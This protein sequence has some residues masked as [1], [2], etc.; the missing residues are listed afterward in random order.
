MLKRPLT[1]ALFCLLASPVL[2]EPYRD[3]AT[4]LGVEI[5]Q[6][7]AHEAGAL[8]SDYKAGV[9]F[10][11][12]GGGGLMCY[13]GFI[14]A[15][16]RSIYPQDY[17]NSAMASAE[18]QQFLAGEIGAV[19]RIESQTIISVNGVTGTEFAAHDDDAPGQV[20]FL[21][22][23]ETAPGRTAMTCQASVA[24]QAASLALFHDILNSISFPQ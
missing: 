8:T 15:P 14:E 6:G 20:L 22:M 2:A 1:V 21:V 4:G 3:E 5:P 17:I 18:R 24:E 9:Q 19:Y 23:L 16:D 7:Y 11:S 13:L 10:A 12:P